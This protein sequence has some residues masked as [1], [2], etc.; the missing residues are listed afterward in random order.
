MGTNTSRSNNRR[1]LPSTTKNVASGPGHKTRKYVDKDGFNV[2]ESI[3]PTGKTIIRY[4]ESRNDITVIINTESVYHSSYN[5]EYLKALERQLN[6]YERVMDFQMAVLDRKLDD[7][8][9]FLDDDFLDF[10][11][12]DN[13]P[14]YPYSSSNSSYSSSSSSK[15]GKSGSSGFGLGCLFWSIIAIIVVCIVI[16]GLGAL[17]KVIVDFLASVF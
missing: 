10:S 13:Y 11:F 12:L 3:S 4:S 7:L 5:P 15:S 17:G 9:K 14:P 1:N 6:T 2:I 16:F 8:D